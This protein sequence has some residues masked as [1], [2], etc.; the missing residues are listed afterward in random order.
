MKRTQLKNKY[1]KSRRFSDKAA[2]SRQRNIC[3]Y[4][5]R[6]AKIDFYSKLNPACITD[7]N[8]FWGV[9][10]PFF[11]DKKCSSDNIRLMEDNEIIDNDL[12]TAE[13]FNE[14]FSMAVKN[15]NIEP[16]SATIMG[17]AEN[18]PILR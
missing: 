7:N 8:K 15:L 5:I 16:V 4:L 9:V 3:N 14:F 12:N 13:I 1:L 17:E 11:S 2:Y 10:K 18:H 6:K